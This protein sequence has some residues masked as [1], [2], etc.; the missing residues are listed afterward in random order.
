MMPWAFCEQRPKKS[1][2]KG[3]GALAEFFFNPHR[4]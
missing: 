4:G 3:S 2:Y 1:L